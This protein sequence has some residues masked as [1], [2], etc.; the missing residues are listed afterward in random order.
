MAGIMTASHTGTDLV[1]GTKQV[2]VSTEGV[3]EGPQ[4]TDTMSHRADLD[5]V[6]AASSLTREQRAGTGHAVALAAVT[7]N[8]RKAI[9]VQP[10]G[11]GLVAHHQQNQTASTDHPNAISSLPL[12]LFQDKNK[13]ESRQALHV[14]SCAAQTI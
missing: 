3:L 13:N 4:K 2:T 5:S 8:L 7:M 9:T 14:Q 10:K 11:G 1:T 6:I 12:P